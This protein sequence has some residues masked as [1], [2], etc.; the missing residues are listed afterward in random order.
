MNKEK[1]KYNFALLIVLL[2][3][4]FLL[5]TIY[6]FINGFFGGL[7]LYIV[8]FPLYNFMIK[9]GIS[10]KVSAWI[11][12]LLGLF[13]IL[14]PL[15][16]LLGLVGYEIFSLFQDP[17]LISD[18]SSIA[19]KSIIRILPS[20]NQE[21]LNSQI[22][23]FGGSASSLFLNIA[24]NIGFFFISLFIAFFLLYF[25]LIY[26]PIYN[27]IRE[28]IPF[29]NKNSKELTDKL[30]DIA[31]STVFV[32]AIIALIQGGL[33]TIAFLIFG[34]KGAYLWGFIAAF[35]SFLPFI[36]PPL[37]WI[38]AVIIQALQG[39]YVAAGG[40]LVFGL[41]LSNIDNLLRP[42]F[43]EKISRIHP[44]ETLIGVFIGVYLF[45]LIGIFVGPLLLALT[46]LVL[47]MFKEE[48]F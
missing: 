33:L 27:K 30:K 32:G 6:I 43:G 23:K 48:Y 3:I 1:S 2:L 39:N 11:I 26:S 34:I 19:S 13:V 42:Y 25:M 18:L 37:V 7:L 9:K 47:K 40:V 28:V 45:G 29:N 20:L 4:A 8:L 36:G 14:L 5:Y 12:I 38:P 41:V 24:S 16:I 44:L 22:I 46:V 17:N 31:Y 10:K 15:F 35:L 21:F